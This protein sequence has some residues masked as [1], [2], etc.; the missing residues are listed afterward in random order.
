MTFVPGKEAVGPVPSGAVWFAVGASGL[1]VRDGDALLPTTEDLEALGVPVSGD[2][3]LGTLDEAPVLAAVVPEST[4]LTGPWRFQGLRALL[5]TFDE[6]RFAAAGRAFHIYDWVT[7]SRF[8]GRCGAAMTRV[9]AERSMKC[10]A[11]SLTQYPRIAPAIIVLVR[12][13]ERALLAHNSRFPAPFFST[14]AGFSGIGET[15]EETLRREVL[16][17]VGV[18]VGALRYFGSQP[19]PFPHSLM[20]A[21][22]AEWESGEISV[23]GDEIGAADWF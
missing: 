19:W 5:G 20:I 6:A 3:P 10:P 11:C 21:F 1:V 13:G 18:R 12:R 4:V 14:L 7:T 9:L 2:H 23:D 8:C 17:E 15:L 22:M 16:E